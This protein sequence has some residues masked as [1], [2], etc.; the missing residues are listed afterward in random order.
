MTTPQ[1]SIFPRG[2]VQASCSRY[3][4]FVRQAASNSTF[5]AFGF[6]KQCAQHCAVFHKQ[7]LATK[8]S[9]DPR[10][11]FWVQHPVAKQL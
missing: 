1:M 8:Q 9:E 10:V 5:G 2:N 11:G 6:Y 3:R 7:R 4:S